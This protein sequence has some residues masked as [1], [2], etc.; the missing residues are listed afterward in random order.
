MV[1]G[2][3]SQTDLQVHSLVYHTFLSQPASSC[4]RLH[5]P[6]PVD[7][8]IFSDSLGTCTVGPPRAA[9]MPWTESLCANGTPSPVAATTHAAHFTFWELLF[10]RPPLVALPASLTSDSHRLPEDVVPKVTGTTPGLG[11]CGTR[12]KSAMQLTT[13]LNVHKTKT[14]LCSYFCREMDLPKTAI[15]FLNHV[16]GQIR[17]LHVGYISGLHGE[18]SWE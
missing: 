14:R 18:S 11:K 4:G 9:W 12:V 16:W 3:L 10:W 5:H 1:R 15:P 7:P 13:T 2:P 8:V 6:P 17:G